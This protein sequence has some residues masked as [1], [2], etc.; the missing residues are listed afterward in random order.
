MAILKPRNRIVTFRVAEDEFEHLK[1]LSVAEGARSLS[2][3][4]RA[5]VCNRPNGRSAAREVELD[6]RV[7]KLDGKVDELDRAIKELTQLIGA[8]SGMRRAD[9]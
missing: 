7:R 8:G 6:A 3:Y 2:D 4:A 5:A 9:A 1:N